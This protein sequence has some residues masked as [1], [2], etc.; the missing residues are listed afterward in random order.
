MERTKKEEFV[1]ELREELAGAKSVVLAHYQGMD[2]N[3]TAEM[4]AD[5]R[6]E[7]VTYRVIKNTLAKLAVKDTEQEVLTDLFV[8][9]TAIAYSTEDAVSPA[10][11]FKK[12]SKASDHFTIRGGFLEGNLLDEQ[13]VD[14]LASMPS[15]EELQAKFLGLLQAVPSKFLRTLNAGPQQFLMVLKAKA[16]QG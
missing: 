15:K 4:R 1:A 13:A 9:P 11:L 8:G 12:Y 10:K 6:K 2:A 16:E 14:Q 7:G 5:F 3:M